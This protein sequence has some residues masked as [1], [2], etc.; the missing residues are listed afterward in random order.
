MKQ[1]NRMNQ[2]EIKCIKYVPV[3]YGTY[4]HM[5][6]FPA[7]CGCT[8]QHISAHDSMY[9]IVLLFEFSCTL[10]ASLKAAHF[11]QPYYTRFQTHPSLLLRQF[12]VAFPAL[13]LPPT[14]LLH[15][16]A[17]LSRSGPE[18][19][20]PQQQPQAPHRMRWRRRRRRR[21]RSAGTCAC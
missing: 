2:Y 4:F 13:P 3:Y 16:F 8:Y 17:S 10:L 6:D 11:L 5:L 21:R 9:L 19:S 18:V 14:P 20:Q 12:H 15:P 7:F 1:Y